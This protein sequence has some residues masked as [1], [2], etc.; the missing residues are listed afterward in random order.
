MGRGGVKA[1]PHLRLNISSPQGVDARV[2]TPVLYTGA[3]SLSTPVIQRA[4]SSPLDELAGFGQFPSSAA[5]DGAA[6]AGERRIS[7]KPGGVACPLC[8]ALFPADAIEAHA[9][10]CNGALDMPAA[11]SA[12]A[13]ASAVPAPARH[14]AVSA[15]PVTVSLPPTSA[16][17]AAP[18]PAPLV[19]SIGSIAPTVPLP[20]FPRVHDT[21]RLLTWNVWFDAHCMQA[22]MAAIGSVIER[23]Q[24]HF[25]ALQEVTEESFEMVRRAAW[26]KS[27]HL[28]AAPA[29]PYF[30]LLLSKF[31]LLQLRRLPFESQMARD[32]LCANV[33]VPTSAGPRR[34]TLATSHLESERRSAHVRR[35][36]LDTALRLLKGSRQ[37][38]RSALYCG[39]MNLSSGEAVDI[40]AKHGWADGWVLLHG[41]SKASERGGATY[42]T[43]TNGMI[44]S[45]SRTAAGY[46]A[47]YD[48]IW[49][50]FDPSAAPAAGAAATGPASAEAAERKTAPAAAG[51]SP[52]VSFSAEWRITALERVGLCAL[53]LRAPERY[54]QTKPYKTL[55]APEKGS[56]AAAAA[57][58]FAGSSPSASAAAPAVSGSS[59]SVQSWGSLAGATANADTAVFPS[60]HFGLLITLQL[61]PGP[62]AGEGA[63]GF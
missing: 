43:K 19:G 4:M 61:N 57:A 9:S 51:A 14:V 54:A 8:Q 17:A 33:E 30:T 15:R 16:S 32:L 55:E 38:T 2:S 26:S 40:P 50:R 58:L 42:D 6:G 29:A 35:A 45:R 25:V 21:L 48:R 46:H 60:D 3:G 37:G 20:F 24:P 22:R 41:D 27:Y 63:Q 49:V 53:D 11:V 12:V 7:P 56:A 39:D 18:S 44:A 10:N 34:L 5:G 31:P 59:R 47:R 28:S 1:P 23:E 13:S 52:A 36:Q 62:A